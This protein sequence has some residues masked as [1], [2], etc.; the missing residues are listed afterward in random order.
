VLKKYAAAGAYSG[1]RRSEP[2]VI[3]GP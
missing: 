2:V 3:V 1:L